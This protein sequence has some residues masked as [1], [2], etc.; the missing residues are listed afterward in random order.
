MSTSATF[1]L[2][3]TLYDI[4]CSAN[5]QYL[6]VANGYL[7][8]HSVD[9]GGTW[10]I[11]NMGNL[12]PY[13]AITMDSTGKYVAAIAT[14]QVVTSTDYGATFITTDAPSIYAFNAIALDV[15][16]VNLVV[17]TNADGI[18]WSSD[19]G[20]SWELST[21]PYTSYASV[22]ISNT[23]DHL[24]GASNP[25]GLYYYV[26]PPA[27]TNWVAATTSGM[28]TLNNVQWSG[29]AAS[30]SGQY[31]VGYC[32]QGG[33]IYVSTDYGAS[34]AQ[35][36]ADYYS[37][38]NDLVI[39]GDGMTMIAL[40]QTN[41]LLYSYNYGAFWQQNSVLPVADTQNNQ[42]WQTLTA[43]DN[44][45][46]IFAARSPDTVIFMSDDYGDSYHNMT[47]YTSS[48]SVQNQYFVDSG[49]SQNGQYVVFVTSGYAF[50]SSNF[51]MLFTQVSTYSQ[52]T[53][54]SV[55][56]SGQYMAAG[57]TD[58]NAQSIWVSSDFGM[59]WAQAAVPTGES[60]VSVAMDS[61]GHGA[62]LFGAQAYGGLFSEVTGITA[63]PT[64]YSVPT[65]APSRPTR[66][67]TAGTEMP[68]AMPVG[69]PEYFI[70]DTQGQTGWYRVVSSPSGQYVVGA[71]INGAPYY[72]S[73][74]G[75]S[76]V[77]STLDSTM[78]GIAD[79]VF[80]SS[81]QYILALQDYGTNP[82]LKS[83]NYGKSYAIPYTNNGLPSG[84]DWL[85]MAADSSLTY[86]HA[87]GSAPD[88]Y[89]Q[90]TDGGQTFTKVTI[91][92][93]ESNQMSPYYNTIVSVIYMSNNY[94]A[95]FFATT[96]ASDNFHALATSGNG[97]YVTAGQY[98]SIYV[99][100]NYGAD[101]TQATLP[102]AIESFYS[103][104]TSS[105]GQ[106][107]YAII[108]N[109]PLLQSFDYG[110]TWTVA[111]TPVNQN[112]PTYYYRA[113]SCDSA[114]E[115]VYTAVY[116][117]GLYFYSD[118]YTSPSP[119]AYTAP[120]PTPS[121][122]STWIQANA[123][124][125]S[126]AGIALSQSGQYA[127]AYGQ[128]G[129]G[130]FISSDFG[131]SFGYTNADNY[132]VWMGVVMSS[133]ASTMF[134]LSQ[135][136]GIYMSSD[137]GNSWT[138]NNNVPTY[139]YLN[140]IAASSD[141]QYVFVGATNGG[142][143]FI[144]S[145]GGNSF[146]AASV[147]AYGYAQNTWYAIACSE[148]GQYIAA[149]SYSYIFTSNNSGESWTQAT[150]TTYVNQQRFTSL[151]SSAS[152]Q[153]MYGVNNNYYQGIFV[154]SDYGVTWS[155]AVNSV[156]SYYYSITCDSTGMYVS[157]AT[158]SGSVSVY[159]SVDFGLN[160]ANANAPC[161]SSL[162]S[163]PTPAPS[164][165]TRQPTYRP[166]QYPTNISYPSEFPTQPPVVPDDW[167]QSNQSYGYWNGV[168]TSQSGQYVI[169]Y[170]NQGSSLKYSINYGAEYKQSTVN[171][172]YFYGA[173]ISDTNGQ[174]FAI[175]NVNGLYSSTDYGANFVATSALPANGG[176]TTI[177][178]SSDLNYVFV[179]SNSG[180]VAVSYSSNGGASFSTSTL[181][182]QNS[183]V[184]LYSIACSANGQFVV[185][186][187]NGGYLYLS[188]DY[189]VNFATTGNG[190]YSYF[191]GLTA[192]ETG[193]YFYAVS[194]S[195]YGIYNSSD[196]GVTWSN[197]D[198]PYSLYSYKSIATSSSGQTVYASAQNLPIIISN[199]FGGSYTTAYAP[200]YYGTYY[201]GLATD[202]T[203]QIAYASTNYNGLYLHNPDV[204]APT[205]APTPYVAPTSI[206]T[207]G[208]NSWFPSSTDL[209]NIGWTGIATCQSGQ[210]VIAFANYGGGIYYSADGGIT[211][212]KSDAS[213][214]AYW[215]AA[216]Y[217]SAG[218]NAL[219]LDA[220]S[221]VYA[222]SNGGKNW[223]QTYNDNTWYWQTL[224]A[225]QD[226]Q[227]VYLG[228][229]G[230]DLLKS[231]DGGVTFDIVESVS[232]G[233]DTSWAGLATSYSGQFVVAATYDDVVVSTDYGVTFTIANTPS[234]ASYEPVAIISSG[235]YM[236]AA[237]SSYY[238][239]DCGIYVSSDY[240]LTWQQSSAPTGNGIYSLAVDSTG[241]FGVGVMNGVPIIQSNDFGVTW[242][243]GDASKQNA[244]NWE[245]VASDA[246]GDRW[247]A[248]VYYTNPQYK[249][250][251]MPTQYP[252]VAPTTQRPSA[253]PTISFI[254]SDMPSLR[255]STEPSQAPSVVSTL[256]PSESPSQIPTA[257]PSWISTVLPSNAP[258]APGDP[259]EAPVTFAPTQLPTT[260]MP[261]VTPTV[262]HTTLLPS[263]MPVVIATTVP[264]VI[265]SGSPA[266]TVF[267]VPTVA[268]F[269][270]PSVS[271]TTPGEKSPTVV[272]SVAPTVAAVSFSATQTIVGLTVSQYY[273]DVTANSLAIAQTASD[274]MTDIDPEDISGI[275]ATYPPATASAVEKESA[276]S[277]QHLRRVLQS[278]TDSILVTYLVATNV[279]GASYSSLTSELSTAV[280]TGAFTTLM[281]Q[282]AAALGATDL[283]TASSTSVTTTNNVPA[284]L[285]DDES[286]T[287]S[288]GAIAGIVI[289]L[290]V[291]FAFA[292]A[293]VIYY[294]R[295]MSAAN[296]RRK[297]SN[298]MAA[299]N[300]MEMQEKTAASSSSSTE[301]EHT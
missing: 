296:T 117:G 123:P 95:T 192:S 289:A 20:V 21:A 209:D 82:L 42:Y 33:G 146:T 177:A 157:A 105:S 122:A 155:V 153:Y 15:S 26:G 27:P 131:Y 197:S 116:Y 255:P 86:V 293:V 154:S 3:Q 228:A 79:A 256:R 143:L 119:T 274:V 185:A 170:S 276:E 286:D 107:I 36:T 220:S 247:F 227:T 263:V 8:Y 297:A 206:P 259:T 284:S 278:S 81:E 248:A 196:Y 167:Y 4:A 191:V 124:Y 30:Q 61:S 198:S 301:T 13:L 12:Q 149:S 269:R 52:Y 103:L 241:Q 249:V 222:S 73:D 242:F 210:N 172:D 114:G 47:I 237:S 87:L 164:R 159:N 189:G 106:N 7:V 290:I 254:P 225:S 92:V 300:D 138:L 62:M 45:Q 56:S 46:Y 261:S 126:Y 130:I 58:Y 266:P 37:Y 89:Y 252:T 207:T 283:A 112:V 98:G 94:G 96:S 194:G 282:N 195:S 31:V 55:S 188:S 125:S 265:P 134:A 137:Y 16:G 75:R 173:V 34:F 19:F 128:Y 180:N 29:I 277:T 41:G 203:G 230:G 234:G 1:P 150:F 158:T 169:A 199:D 51:G 64:V 166:T 115:N 163:V 184:Y 2:T 50:V 243:N 285:N 77:I 200:N 66:Q 217:D 208:P 72:S 171:Y 9:F 11:G 108:T 275:I 152:G 24:Y 18:Y 83:G 232:N 35:S 132:A 65:P 156:S 88:T 273:L 28:T 211:Y 281:N 291:F 121:V 80:G 17:G 213:T 85:A 272:P 233:S 127:V 120:T 160:W 84:M 68:T 292:A 270:Q 14:Y 214:N 251:A 133:S 244:W 57:T 238:N 174:V 175:S 216:I 40:Q 99:S 299:M 268:P 101:F 239:S 54:V 6:A 118:N 144:S 60:Y 231:T 97:Q 22:A 39:S 48:G 59:T 212:K 176:Y 201:N 204:S 71:A 141:L 181:T 226:L 202:S 193:Q 260:V 218:T 5:G 178:A 148:S 44:F 168:A 10:A 32:F 129:A 111:N 182:S 109:V 74:F 253:E 69:A 240:G 264:S 90:S 162:Y 70:A 235:Q 38:V 271:P 179:A 91:I 142:S 135:Y 139:S 298:V 183:Y 102:V 223:T 63:S 280:S 288:G 113:V 187:E 147:S 279:P 78:Y 136:Y 221:G 245:A 267:R 49:C 294:N 100:S 219:A 67:P 287:L 224:A 43:S 25:N 205:F 161:G 186:A 76:Y 258:V 250:N 236:F 257:S 295:Q 93:V 215:Y 165:P 262:V 229:S 23:S 110:V 246:S 145:D 151:D 104:S 140:C 53:S 190:V